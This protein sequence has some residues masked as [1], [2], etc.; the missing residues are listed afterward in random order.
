MTAPLRQYTTHHD[1]FGLWH[2]PN[3]KM[4]FPGTQSKSWYI[5]TNSIGIRDDREFSA[6][7]ADGIT[8]ILLFGDSFTFGTGVDVQERYSNLIEQKVNN[9]EI[10]NFGVG[11]TGID[12]QFLIYRHLGSNYESDII[13][14]CPYLNNVTRCTGTFH[15]YQDRQGNLIKR[16]KPYFKIESDRLVLENVP[17]PKEE[18]GLKPAAFDENKLEIEHHRVGPNRS[19]LKARLVRNYFLNTNYKY[20]LIKLIPIQ[21]YPE[22]E[23]PIHPA[24]LLGKRILTEFIKEAGKKFIIAPLPSWSVM[25]N[26]KLARYRDRFAELHNPDGGVYVIDIL[27]YFL[28]LHFREIKRCFI[29]K[30]DNHYSE[31]GHRIAAEALTTEFGKIKL[32]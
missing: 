5:R 4:L 27:P 8:R 1:I 9:L 30:Y 3:V 14:I 25:M 6:S 28:D 7:K 19:N 26:P 31:M 12:R 21:P 16:P 22:Y 32:L 13:L 18:A 11:S 29:S 10:M 20:W 17:V 2:L 23:S 15:I 24:W